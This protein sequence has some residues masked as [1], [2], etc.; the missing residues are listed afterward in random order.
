VSITELANQA[1]ARKAKR[2][3]FASRLVKQ[4]ASIGQFSHIKL[5]APNY[6]A[7]YIGAMNTARNEDMETLRPFFDNFVGGESIGVPDAQL[8]TVAK[9]CFVEAMG[10]ELSPETLAYRAGRVAALV[11]MINFPS[12]KAEKAKRMTIKQAIAEKT[13]DMFAEIDDCIDRKDYSKSFEVLLDEAGCKTID[14]KVF[15]A[16]YKPLLAELVALVK[17]TDEQVKE[18]YGYRD[19][20]AYMLF[21]G[22]M[23]VAANDFM[24][25]K[26]KSRLVNVKKSKRSKKIVPPAQIVSKMNFMKEETTLGLTSIDPKKIIG[27]TQVWVYNT[28]TKQLGTYFAEKDQVM[29]VKGTSIL[30]YDTSTSIQKKVKTPSKQVPPVVTVGKVELRR[31]MDKVSGKPK[32]LKPRINKDTIILRVV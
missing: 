11:D 20:K 2:A 31:I 29:T 28:K 22:N 18:A 32:P 19:V 24:T 27:A 5:S 9:I 8:A 25:R 30:F 1:A 10:A 15:Q 7:L 4:A 16:K 14:L 13:R 3:K 6:K 23:L 26:N 12:A 17:N 21:I